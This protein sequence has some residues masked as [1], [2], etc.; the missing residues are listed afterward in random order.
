MVRAQTAS[1][2]GATIYASAIS[3]VLESQARNLMQVDMFDISITIVFHKEGGYAMPALASMNDLV[4]RAR[5][6]GLTIEARALLDRADEETKRIVLHRGEWLDDIENVSFGEL[7]L[8]RNYGARTARGEFLSFL[9][10]DDLWGEEW[11]TSAYHLAISQP[12]AI[13]HPEL[14]YFFNEDDFDRRTETEELSPQIESHLMWHK[15]STFA[16]PNAI[17]MQNLW[18]ANVF[19][20]RDIHLKHPYR[21]VDRE[22]GMGFE[23]WSWNLETLHADIPHLVVQDTVHLIRQK[24]VGSLGRSLASEGILPFIPD[25]R[26]HSPRKSEQSPSSYITEP[27]LE[28]LE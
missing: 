19:A 15:A 23:D 14:L 22:K 18:S 26:F 21:A 13:W 5:G 10:G 7:G 16:D 4:E 1:M 25:G 2:G 27:L 8:T 11:L 20:S 12:D 3:T 28:L 9:D 24:P 17:L 6:E